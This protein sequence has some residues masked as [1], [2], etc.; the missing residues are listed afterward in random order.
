MHFKEF[1]LNISI[2]YFQC[3]ASHKKQANKEDGKATIFSYFTPE[4]C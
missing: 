3:C 2:I 4:V 1:S